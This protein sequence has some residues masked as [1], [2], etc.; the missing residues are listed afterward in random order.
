[1]K[2]RLLIACGALLP[3][4]LT[5]AIAVGAAG[6]GALEPAACTL[7]A[8][9]TTGDGGAGGGSPIAIGNLSTAQMGNARTIYAVAMSRKL[10]V[11]AA[12]IALGTAL[13]ESTLRNL[14][15]AVDHDSLGLFQQRP[16]QGWGTPSQILDPVYASNSFYNRLVRVPGWQTRALTDAAQAVQRSAYP[17]AYAKWETL[18]TQLAAQFGTEI[19][20]APSTDLST[21]ADEGDGLPDTG[22][23]TLPDGL[24][25]PPGTSPVVATAIAWA[26]AQRG[27]PYTFGGDCTAPHSG[28]K[29]RQCDCSS[30]MQQAYRHAGVRIDRTTLD[31]VHNGVAVTNVSAVAPGDL[32]FIA[33]SLGSRSRPRHVGMYIGQGLV[34]Q[35]P[36]TGDV[37]KISTLASWK[38]KIAAVRRII[39]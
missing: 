10:P 4:M 6:S 39:T 32:V 18:A 29:S 1:M 37:V 20:A 5:T 8:D 21:C 31:Q 30:L 38:N 16:S 33:G 23:V 15:T 22:D 25:L 14:D 24:T 11:R 19:P 27:T 26:L 36:R 9:T 7:P 28:V 3:V 13:Q 2:A 35:A 17:N 34:V 12:V